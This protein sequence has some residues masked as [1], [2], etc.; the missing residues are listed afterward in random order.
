MG[1]ACASNMLA[2]LFWVDCSQAAAAVIGLQLLAHAA[3]LHAPMSMPQHCPDCSIGKLGLVSAMLVT[4]D[5][6]LVPKTAE[7]VP[8]RAVTVAQGDA[9]PTTLSHV[10]EDAAW[11]VTPT[12]E[13]RNVKGMQA[14]TRSRRLYQHSWLTHSLVHHPAHPCGSLSRYPC[15]CTCHMPAHD[16]TST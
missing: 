1:Q 6:L 5:K 8:Y 4:S 2:L 7:A 13:V 15:Q 10:H 16:T 9:C 14:V 12:A 3:V 11:Y